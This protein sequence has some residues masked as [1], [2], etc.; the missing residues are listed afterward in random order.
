MCSFLPSG[1]TV[2]KPAFDWSHPPPPCSFPLPTL[3][4]GIA[5]PSAF[6]AGSLHE[7]PSAL[8]QGEGA[9]DGREGEE[10]KFGVQQPACL[11]D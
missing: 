4:L 8:W 9:K 10:S 2:P 7:T 3:C 6:P 5:S 11:V 1:T